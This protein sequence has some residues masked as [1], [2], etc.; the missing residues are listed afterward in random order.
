VADHLLALVA[1]AVVF[2]AIGLVRT[3]QAVQR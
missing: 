1:I 3:R 2:G